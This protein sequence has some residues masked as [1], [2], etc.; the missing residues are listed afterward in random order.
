MSILVSFLI[1][2]FILLVSHLTVD[3]DIPDEMKVGAWVV[4]GALAVLYVVF[5]IIL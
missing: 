3:S 2:I 5:G 4:F 1:C